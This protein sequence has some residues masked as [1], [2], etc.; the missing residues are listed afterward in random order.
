MTKSV[1]DL[2][3]KILQKIPNFVDKVLD[4][5]IHASEVICRQGWIPQW[6]KNGIAEMI[7]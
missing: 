1:D 5:L 6:I 4:A 3:V 7:I 2:A